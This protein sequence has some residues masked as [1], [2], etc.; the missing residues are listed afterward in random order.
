MF[1]SDIA[2][3][4]HGVPLETRRSR[5]SI[6]ARTRNS[7]PACAPPVRPAKKRSTKT[8]FTQQ[9][10]VGVK[11]VTMR[12]VPLQ[13]VA[14]LF[15]LVGRV[16]GG[17]LEILKVGRTCGFRSPSFQMRCTLWCETPTAAA[18]L[19]VLHF[20]PFGGCTTRVRICCTLWVGSHAFRPRPRAQADVSPPGGS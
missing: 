1:S 13:P 8:K 4:L 11:W 6:P 14:H 19:R 2:S 18:M 3:A 12:R 7:V 16:V 17:S 10:P 9:L 20:F 15:V 5:R